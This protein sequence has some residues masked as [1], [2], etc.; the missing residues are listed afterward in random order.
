MTSLLS[1][2][3]V[4]HQEAEDN[5]LVIMRKITVTSRRSMDYSDILSEQ[6]DAEPR[7]TIV[8]VENPTSLDRRFNSPR[9]FVTPRSF[10]GSVTSPSIKP[11]S[12]AIKPLLSV[13]PVMPKMKIDSPAE[14]NIS[15]LLPSNK[16]KLDDEFGGSEEGNYNGCLKVDEE[17]QKRTSLH[18][19]VDEAGEAG[20]Q[21]LQHLQQEKVPRNTEI[22]RI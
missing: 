13:K 10:P 7:E 21:H 18:L 15:P 17:D 8:P 16:D 12:P 20:L 22:T 5:N 11:V 6:G 1:I 4:Q 19:Y 3:K 2:Y 14:T 9:D